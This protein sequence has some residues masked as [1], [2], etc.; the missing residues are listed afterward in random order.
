MPIS[1]PPCP[2]Q[3]SGGDEGVEKDLTNRGAFY[4]PK[5]AVSDD[6]PDLLEGDFLGIVT[7]AEGLDCGHAGIAV[8]EEGRLHLLHASAGGGGLGLP[9][10]PWRTTAAEPDRMGLMVGRIR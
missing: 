7:A 2:T 9:R 5:T 4:Y 6:I 8:L 1:I 10:N 3:G